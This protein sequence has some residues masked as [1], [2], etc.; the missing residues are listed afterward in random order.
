[1]NGR[2]KFY[3]D[4]RSFG[5]I[6]KDGTDYFFHKSDVKNIPRKIYENDIIESFDVIAKQKGPTAKNIIFEEKIVCPVCSWR[7]TKDDE[8][9]SN[10]NCEFTLK[11]V[12]GLH[13]DISDEELKLYK[14][15]LKDETIKF[16]N[17]KKK[18]VLKQHTSKILDGKIIVYDEIKGEG[19]IRGEDALKYSFDIENI[20]K[21][22]EIKIGQF[23]KFNPYIDN[24]KLVA[25]KITLTQNNENKDTKLKINNETK[26]KINNET[27]LTKYVLSYELQ[28]VVILT[29]GYSDCNTCGGSGTCTYCNGSGDFYFDDGEVEYNS[30]VS[31]HGNGLCDFCDDDCEEYT[32]EEFAKYDYFI[33]L[34]FSNA[35]NRKIYIG[36]W[37]DVEKAENNK[38]HFYGKKIIDKLDSLC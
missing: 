18:K 4:E 13:T 1:M 14:E 2:V 12:K 34:K 22:L 8:N 26:L 23:V 7:N 35:K 17:F 11:Y 37:E 21:P 38:I 20:N 28:V 27:I 10:S 19:F 30:C 5:M 16:N 15:R 36:S 24:S 32:G 31:C 6:K 9:C 29:N 33:S 3:N 25:I